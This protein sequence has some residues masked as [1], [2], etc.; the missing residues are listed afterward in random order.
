MGPTLSKH[1]KSK[2]KTKDAD[3][4]KTLGLKRMVDDIAVN[5]ILTMDNESLK[6]LNEKSYCDEITSLTSDILEKEFTHLELQKIVKHV[7]DGTVISETPSDS[8]PSL[9]DT[10]FFVKKEALQ[11]NPEEKREICNEIAKFYVKIAHL[12]AAI[13]KTINPEYIYKDFFGNI[14][15]TR[16]KKSIPKN[17]KYQLY[18]LNLCNQRLNSL[19]GKTDID[20][21]VHLG[22]DEKSINL[23]PEYCNIH[24]KSDGEIKT[25]EEE[26]GIPELM[27]L[28]Y[29]ADYDYKTGEFRGMSGPTKEDYQKDLELFYKTFTAAETMPPTIT[30]FGD[31]KLKNYSKSKFC[32]EFERNERKDTGKLDKNKDKNTEQ[33]IGNYK[34]E[35]FRLY[36]SNIGEMIYSVNE[37]QDKL[38]DILSEVFLHDISKSNPIQ[39][40]P[41]LTEK[42][43]QFLIE[44]ARDCIKEMY[45]LCERDFVEG[46]KIYEA[47]VESKMFDTTRRQIET[48]EKVFERIYS[49]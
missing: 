49:K 42:K 10:V 13:M 47:I 18:K 27:N 4:P 29:D 2:N 41:E 15:R 21:M 20:E 35:L 34:D 28:Y 22:T 26:P 11:E 40:H 12:Y 43:L 9:E 1:T 5:Y 33:I 17:T 3:I 23:Q 32:G 6:K 24:V 25:L 44:N 38:L 7:D 14:I 46:I 45:I 36:S 8:K 31:I 48:L 30:K 19:L 16:D 37:K 39:I